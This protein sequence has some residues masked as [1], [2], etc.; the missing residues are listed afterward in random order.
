MLNTVL[1]G[2]S[3]TT[4]GQFTLAGFLI[5][6]VSA[7]LLGALIAVVHQKTTPTS[8]S[9]TVTLAI[10]PAIV[11]VIIMMVN[12]SI[13]AGIAVA[14]AFSLV[15]FRSAPGT[16]KEIGSIFLAM[17]TG[18]ACGMGYPHFGLIFS[19]ILCLVLVLYRR[20]RFGEK[21]DAMLRKLVVMM[22]ED[23][24]YTHA[25]DSIFEKYTL[26]HRLEK[27]KTTSLGSLNKL[28]YSIRLKAAGIEKEFIDEIRCRNGNLE[29]S[30]SE[31]LDPATEL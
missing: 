16:A 12:G 5:C 29:I 2:L 3:A 27:V 28:T 11:T 22:P 6:L 25:F 19:V 7:L 24:N 10:I 20:I 21:S 9:F 18:L 30:L 8:E 15:R 31:I 1:S 14:G 17:A 13:G 4:N 23:L 26:E